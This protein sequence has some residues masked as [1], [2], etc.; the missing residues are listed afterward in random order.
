M[1]FGQTVPLFHCHKY[2]ILTLFIE[3]NPPPPPQPPPILEHPATPSPPSLPSPKPSHM[4]PNYPPTP[5]SYLPV[6][7]PI[8]MVGRT[9]L[10]FSTSSYCSSFSVGCGETPSRT[11]SGALLASCFPLPELLVGV[12]DPEEAGEPVARYIFGPVSSSAA[13]GSAASH[14]HCKSSNKRGRVFCSIRNFVVLFFSGFLSDP[15][16]SHRNWSDF[17]VRYYTIAV[18]SWWCRWLVM[19]PSPNSETCMHSPAVVYLYSSLSHSQD[20]G[21]TEHQ[22]Y[23]FQ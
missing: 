16:Y 21:H 10:I 9:L 1:H 5:R 18:I 12:V 6:C 13:R 11:W 20:L 17:S 22:N 2:G 23:H 8:H 19:L 3:I 7:P 4:T 14:Q 15:W